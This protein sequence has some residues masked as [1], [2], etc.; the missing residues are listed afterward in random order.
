MKF[1]FVRIPTPLEF[2]ATIIWNTKEY[3][4]ISLGRFAPIC[5]GWMI[6]AKGKQ[7]S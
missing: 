4:G 3:F 6:G 1:P 2:I 7:K 5:F